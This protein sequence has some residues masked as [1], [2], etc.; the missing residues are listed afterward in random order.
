MAE[1][2]EILAALGYT[3]V[4]TLLNSGNAVF[5]GDD[6][7]PAA[8]AAAISKAIE[9]RLGVLVPVIVKSRREFSAIEAGNSLAATSDNHS[10]VLVAFTLDPRDLRSLAALAALVKPPERFVMGRHAAYLWCPD[11]ILQSEAGKALLGK[12]G[13]SATTRNWATVL[14]L[15]ALLRDDP[16]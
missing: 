8:H 4:R 11:G 3:N 6:R 10:R 15:G 2:R 1:F 13:R 5:T 9:Q 12:A 14:K 16:A 7:A